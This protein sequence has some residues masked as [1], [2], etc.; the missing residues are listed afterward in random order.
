MLTPARPYTLKPGDG[1]RLSQSRAAHVAQVGR[2]RARA[3]SSRRTARRFTTLSIRVDPDAARARRKDGQDGQ[4]GFDGMSWQDRAGSGGP[5]RRLGARPRARSSRPK[6]C[7]GVSIAA[8][9]SSSSCTCSR[10]R[11]RARFSRRSR[12]S[13]R[14][15]PPVRTPLTRQDGIEADRH[16]RG[17]DRL[18]R[19]RHLRAAGAGR[20]AERVPARALSRARTC[21]SPPRCPTATVKTLLS[22]QA[23]DFHWQQDYRYATPIPA[24][25][26]GRAS[27]MRYTYDNSG[28]PTSNPSHPPVRVK[29]G[30]QWWTRWRSSG[31]R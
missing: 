4:P 31:C 25:R 11:R 8:P 1:G 24:S 26:P 10:R 3:S 30:P 27:K 29:L 13:S 12:S 21:A 16:S 14:D 23:L 20:S 22:H 15:Q 28:R 6:A 19:H 5:V 2:V 7:R 17:Q 18:R 9:I